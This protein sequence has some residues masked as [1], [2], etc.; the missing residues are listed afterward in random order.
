M[1]QVA[2]RQRDGVGGIDGPERLV[3]AE[4]V[5]TMRSTCSLLAPPTPAMACFTWFGEYSTTSQPA[6]AASA[7]TIPA[8]WATE[9][10][11]RTLTW[12][13]TRSMA[14]TAGRC[15]R[16]RARTSACSSASRAGVARS[17][18]VRSTPTATTSW[19][20]RS[21]RTRP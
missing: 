5:C 10:A 18:S 2:Q 17:G 8:A 14:T 4:R 19:R 11:V 9:M 12:N 13:S 3:D 21:V 1:G 16:S 7:I 6:A 20:P 15:S